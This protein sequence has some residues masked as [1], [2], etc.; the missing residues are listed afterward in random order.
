MST[1]L[2]RVLVMS[3]FASSAAMIV[4]LALRGWLRARFGARVAYATWALVPIASAVALVPP[5]TVIKALPILALNN[6]LPAISAI[7]VAATPFTFDPLPW[8][9]AAWMLGALL[10]LLGLL[11]QQRNFMRALGRLSAI[12]AGAM[13]SNLSSS[14][15]LRAESISGCPALVGAIQP[16]IVL[17]ADFEQRYDRVERELILAHERT[18]RAR[19]DAQINAL[20]ALLRCVFWFNPLVY[21]A[22]SRFRFDQEL[23]CDAVVISR[24]PEARRRYADAMLKTQLAVLGLPVGCHWQSSHPLRER[25]AMLKHPLPG[26]ARSA[27]GFGIAAALVVGGCYTAW[28]AQPAAVKAAAT[29]EM[30]DADIT[31]R[32]GDGPAQHVDVHSSA[33]EPYTVIDAKD[34]AHWELQGTTTTQDDG[35]FV[36]DLVVTHG[37]KV[38]SRPRLIAQAGEAASILVDN[39]AAERYEAQLVITRIAAAGVKSAPVAQS[40]DRG[41]GY[42]ALKPVAYPP[43]A[44]AARQQGV[45]YVAAHVGADGKVTSARV[46]H[47]DPADARTLADAAVAG[48]KSWTFDPARKGGVDIASDEIVAVAFSLDPKGEA[49]RVEH[50][51][52][53]PIGVAP[54]QP[55]A[56]ET[57]P[58]EDVSYR[59]MFPPNYP[60]AA[61]K[62]KQSARMKFNV[63]VDAHGEPQ[64]VTVANSDPPEAAALFAQASIDAI[65]K[66]HFNPGIKDGKPHAG[67]IEVPIDFE[68]SDDDS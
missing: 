41:A 45:V 9:L 16:R 50:T 23:A 1:E 46:D 30:L 14:D 10:A 47:I 65:R 12:D 31:F 60:P 35:S 37:G 18:H 68:L 52:L 56:G 38:L 19:G 33:G 7:P 51:A 58:S 4:M 32:I 5:P 20:A 26:R 44:L 3:V 64:S 42:R 40:G 11:Q 54:E 25:I 55:V 8:L 36:T 62:A 53:E 61:I 43:A 29:Q 48:V 21:F 27:L 57:P 34:A 39:G 59:L 13:G 49:P 17:P 22:A 63:L 66:W 15:V 67:H 24:F 2:I 6:A 28:A